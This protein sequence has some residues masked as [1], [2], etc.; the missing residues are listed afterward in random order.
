MNLQEVITDGRILANRFILREG[1]VFT[2]IL[3]PGNVYDAIV[4][5]CEEKSVNVDLL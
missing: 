2:A 1:F 3:H 5:V 4:G